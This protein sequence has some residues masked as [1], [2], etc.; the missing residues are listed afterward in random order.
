MGLL[1]GLFAFPGTIFTP[2]IKGFLT[3][4]QR[5]DFGSRIFKTEDAA[6]K[7]QA[8]AAKTFGVFS[9]I[10]RRSDGQYVLLFDPEADLYL[11]GNPEDD[12]AD[13]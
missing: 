13:S 7:A 4:Y 9:G 6:F 5:D 8:R 3:V 2:R 11:N 12:T 10:V 1:K